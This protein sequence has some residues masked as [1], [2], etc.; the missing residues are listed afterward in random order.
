MTRPE[1]RQALKEF[2]V[3]YHMDRKHQTLGNRVLTDDERR[4]FDRTRAACPEPRALTI[5]LAPSTT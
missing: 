4:Q 1:R 2:A 5:R 3:H